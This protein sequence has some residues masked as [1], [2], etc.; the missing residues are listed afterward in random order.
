MCVLI[1][2]NIL[3][4]IFTNYDWLFRLNNYLFEV[5]QTIIL[6]RLMKS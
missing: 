2:I 3:I 5:E 6:A 4:N 1:N